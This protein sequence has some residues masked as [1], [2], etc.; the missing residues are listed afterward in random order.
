MV[1]PEETTTWSSVAT[2][3]RSEG[4]TEP[5]DVGLPASG[6]YWVDAE[7]PAS[8]PLIKDRGRDECREGALDADLPRVRSSAVQIALTHRTVC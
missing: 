2:R 5:R 3:R 4:C 7:P 8:L 1:P 6:V